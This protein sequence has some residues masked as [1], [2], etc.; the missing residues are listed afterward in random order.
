MDDIRIST[1]TPVYL[2]E[3]YLDKLVHKLDSLRVKLI[4][5]NCNLILSE[6]IFVVDGAIDQS[7][8]VLKKL[9]LK[10]VKM[11]PYLMISKNSILNYKLI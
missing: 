6:S 10:I 9:E 1:V 2:G 7:L 11:L 8:T 4:D 5:D 3:K